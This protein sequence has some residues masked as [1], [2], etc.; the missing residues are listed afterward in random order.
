M[1]DVSV[2]CPTFRRHRYIPF[3][4]RQFAKQTFDAE[5]RE[6]VIFDDTPAP[7]P[8]DDILAL[9]VNYKHDDSR[10]YMIWEKRNILNKMCKG[11]VIVCMDDD[12]FY[13]PDRITHALEV[14]HKNPRLMLAGCSSLYIYDMVH[15]NT[16]MFRSKHKN[17]IL[18][19]SFAYRKEILKT[20]KYMNNST[21]CNFN[22]ERSFT[23]QF[24]TR[25][26]QL[27]IA[28]TTVCVSHDS[29]TV[30]KDSFC[31]TDAEVPIEQLGID[32]IDLRLLHTVNPMLYWINMDSATERRT[33]MEG[34]LQHFKLHRRIASIENF[35]PAIAANRVSSEAEVSCLSS[36]LKAMETFLNGGEFCAE[37][38]VI[39][40]DDVELKGIDMLH[41]RVFYYTQR[42]PAN[43]Q[44][45]Q[46][47]V[48]AHNSRA[49]GRSLLRFR[50]WTPD[51]YSTLIYVVRR[52]GAEGVLKKA[53]AAR[54]NPKTKWIADNYLY[55]NA[56]TY[57]VDACFFNDRT[58]L[59]SDIHT[60]NL[61]MHQANH[62]RIEE[63]LASI[64]LHYPFV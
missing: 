22:E 28:K 59:G 24:R 38:C 39:C 18:N 7:Y 43:W 50:K 27:D 5:R 60:S 42:A 20:N 17:H 3:L 29:N 1:I 36:H 9:H 33:Y 58:A 51:N 52:S 64:P 21:K 19:G 46:L 63:E 31:R 23:K 15:R 57:S 30:P 47:H 2:V 10:R 61:P 56:V 44:I 35:V 37:L 6:L 62:E 34:Q 41:E 14:L 4:M 11:D 8:F 54:A 45:L 13:F 25:A 53:R 49:Q 55:K 48:I 32:A 12:D 16:Y 40:E 26:G